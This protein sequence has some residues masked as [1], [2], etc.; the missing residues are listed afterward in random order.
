MILYPFLLLVRLA[1]FVLPLSMFFPHVLRILFVSISYLTC[2][3]MVNKIS[4]RRELLLV[5]D[6][7]SQFMLYLGSIPL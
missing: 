2:K 1:V 3:Q 4:Y 7:K 6:F 5:I